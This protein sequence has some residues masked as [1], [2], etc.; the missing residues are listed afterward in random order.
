MAAKQEKLTIP[1]EVSISKD[2][3]DKLA[4]QRKSQGNAALTSLALSSMCSQFLET[5]ANGGI[6]VKSE[7]LKRI[8]EAVGQEVSNDT[9]L[10]EKVEKAAGRESGQYCVQISIDP[11]LWPSVEEHATVIGMTPQEIMQDM[12]HRMIRDSLSFYISNQTYEPVIYVTD[13][14]GKKFEKMFGK[15]HIT[16]SDILKAL[17][18]HPKEEVAA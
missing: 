11:A 6:L 8:E 10:V 14:Q 17:E 4:A 1:A 15:R 7:N 3:Y 9:Q 5:Y 13:E 12:A 2:A 16:G 18:A